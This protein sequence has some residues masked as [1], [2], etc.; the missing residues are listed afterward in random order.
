MTDSQH[1]LM[2]TYWVEAQLQKFDVVFE[3]RWHWIKNAMVWRRRFNTAHV[4]TERSPPTLAYMSAVRFKRKV[5]SLAS[6][7]MPSLMYLFY[8]APLYSE[9]A[10]KVLLAFPYEPLPLNPTHPREV[11][12]GGFVHHS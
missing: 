11:V 3:D 2:T 6:V 4:V 12:S 8:L 5:L 9:F 7:T 1:V 10:L